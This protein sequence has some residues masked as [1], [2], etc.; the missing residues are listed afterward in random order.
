MSRVMR[1]LAFCIYAKTKILVDKMY[2]NCAADQLLRFC[3]IA[4]TI[5]LQIRNFKL[6]AIF[7]GF[8]AR[9]VLDLV[10]NPEGR[11]S[12]DVVHIKVGLEEV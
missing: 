7:C 9:F 1:K 8:T 12:H 6:L 10:V 11:F 4:S 2:S 3:Y 5:P